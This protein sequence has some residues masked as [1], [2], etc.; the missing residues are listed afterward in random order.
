MFCDCFQ[1]IKMTPRQIGIYENPSGREHTICVKIRQ[2]KHHYYASVVSERKHHG[3]SRA[4]II[5]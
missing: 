3:R 2:L 5:L 4:K 1:G